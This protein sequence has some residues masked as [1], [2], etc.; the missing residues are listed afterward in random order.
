MSCRLLTFPLCPLCTHQEER[1]RRVRER[2]SRE[3]PSALAHVSASTL[4]I[5]HLDADADSATEGSV[6]CVPVSINNTTSLV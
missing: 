3:T 5:V 2:I 1:I 6:D 4:P